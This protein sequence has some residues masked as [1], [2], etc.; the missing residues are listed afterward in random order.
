MQEFFVLTG[1]KLEGLALKKKIKAVEEAA[2]DMNATVLLK[3]GID[4]ISDGKQTALNKTGNPYMTKGG[5]GDTLAGI[6]GSMLAQGHS[7]FISA[8]AAA[9]INGKAGDMAAR[10]RKQ[11]LM[12]SDL[13]ENICGAIGC[14]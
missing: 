3:G 8:C 13:V 9:Y 6:C 2:A 11:S 5:T 12:A 10:R 4:I 1:E 7:P 14:V